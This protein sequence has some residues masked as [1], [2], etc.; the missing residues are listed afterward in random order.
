MNTNRLQ[1]LSDGVFAIVFTLLVLELKV[2]ENLSKTNSY[3]LLHSLYELTPTLIGYFVTFTVM[4]MFWMSHSFL[5]GTFTRS[6]NRQLSALNLLFLCF[7]SLLPFS[8]HLI[9]HYG[10]LKLAA[11]IYGLHL[12]TISLISN[13]I[14]NYALKSNEIDTDHNSPKMISHARTRQRITILFTIAG[15][16][17]ALFFSTSLAFVLFMFPIIFNIIPGG[18]DFIEKFLLNTKNKKIIGE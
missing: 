7:I 9:G 15:L 14:F 13:K 10:E 18:L 12:L 6:I 4:A 2:P 16:L 11:L 1:S 8:A 5:Y 3:E 17:C